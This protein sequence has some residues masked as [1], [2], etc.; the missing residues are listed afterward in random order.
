MKRQFLPLL[1]PQ[2]QKAAKVPA[3]FKA[4][5]QNN[6]GETPSLTGLSTAQQ[7][8]LVMQRTLGNQAV[9]RALNNPSALAGRPKVGRPKQPGR[10][11]RT[12]AQRTIGD[13]HDLTSPRFADDTVLQAV[14]DD[15][16]DLKK[17]D[18]GP[19]VSKLQKAL[20][21]SGHN[22]PKSG[23]D[24]QFGDET[25]Q[26]MIDF[27]EAS[28]VPKAQQDGVVRSVTMER[29][30]AI[31]PPG[32]RPAGT[33]PP[34]KTDFQIRGK[35]PDADTDPKNDNKLFF[36]LGESKLD[37]DEQI[38]I[39]FLFDPDD[40]NLELHGFA[41][42]E[43]SGNA[44]LI[45]ARIQSVAAALKKA[46]HKG[47]RK[48]V[49][50][51]KASEGNMDYRS[52]RVVEV[53]P[54]GDKPSTPDCNL[55]NAK[56]LPCGDSF[57]TGKPE[58]DRLINQAVA[59]LGAS[60]LTK[61]TKDAL[62]SVGLSAADAPQLATNLGK[63]KD[64]LGNMV[65]QHQCHNADCDS[66]CKGGTV[67]YNTGD[68]PTA[69]M[70]VCP[71]FVNEPSATERGDTLI[72]EGSHGTTGLLTEDLAY[73]FQRLI[74][75]LR[76]NEAL[77]NADSYA[78]F[79]RLIDDPSS[80]TV[81]PPV[82]D[83]ETGITNPTEKA[84]LDRSIAF[85]EKCVELSFSQLSALYS[86]VADALKTGAWQNGFYEYM[87][88][89]I[90]PR[91]GLTAPKAIPNSHDRQA[92]AAM[93][94][95]FEQMFNA[96]SEHLTFN[97]DTTPAGVDKWEPGPGHSVTLTQAF[98]DLPDIATKADFLMTKLIEA[99]PDISAGLAPE[100]LEISKLIR[101][102]LGGVEP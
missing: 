19:P 78:L 102:Q 36:E 42:E 91:F 7:T 93:A 94:D 86:E 49:P 72:H 9:S 58:G 29:F 53:L 87:M 31:F 30:D 80:V 63:I 101:T 96:T 77:A 1:D 26:V 85:V 48:P 57:D 67:A 90:A 100:Y 12:I 84:D 62:K 71:A 98:F 55:P 22:L 40:Q 56:D 95:R 10:A 50:N 75:F 28:G 97:K 44:A 4:V 68:G 76:P 23:P 43:G 83:T 70:T 88:S 64:Q 59:A 13:G 54:A 38:K 17:G 52:M 5:P 20:I 21:D 66:G 69:M 16:R 99:T 35:P 8:I 81:G 2:S 6:E 51:V 14:F 39:P 25:E 45:D 3:A 73:R 34:D 74:S 11:Q 65:P 27:Q 18:A 82:P 47:D 60:P 15:E 33:P 24:G 46:G 89:L 79:V 32:P 41:S 92:I 37:G 61:K